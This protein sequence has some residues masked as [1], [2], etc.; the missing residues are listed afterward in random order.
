M[1]WRFAG[2][3]ADFYRDWWQVAQEEALHFEL[4]HTHLNSLGFAYGDFPAHDGLWDMAERTKG[5]VL[6]RLAKC[7]SRSTA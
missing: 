7:T 3:P 6:A 2:M 1:M 5:D 4:L